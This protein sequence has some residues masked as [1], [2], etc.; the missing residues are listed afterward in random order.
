MKP[1][2]EAWLEKMEAR[3]ETNQEKT[4]CIKIMHM[5]TAL[6]GQVSDALHEVLK[7]ATYKKRTDLETS[8]WPQSTI[9][10]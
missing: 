1:M 5:L 3:L 8:N 7:G 9:I 4:E 10:N 2:I 6:Q